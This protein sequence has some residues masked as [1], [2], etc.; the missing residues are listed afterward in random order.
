MESERKF[1]GVLQGYVPY[2]NDESGQPVF[3]KVFD[4]GGLTEDQLT[5]LESHGYSRLPLVEDSA[6]ELIL[7]CY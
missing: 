1:L 3:A 5:M 4:E 2:D 6:D 7:E